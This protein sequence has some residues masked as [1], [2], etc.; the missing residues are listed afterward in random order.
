MFKLTPHKSAQWMY[1]LLALFFGVAFF[2]LGTA[3][4]QAMSPED[5][6]ELAVSFE[7]E[8]MAGVQL[9]AALMMTFGLLF[10]GRWRWSA[11]FRLAGAIVVVAL[12]AMLA[13]SSAFAPNGW[14][15]A[16]YNIGFAGAGMTIA[17]WNLVDVRAAIFW[18]RDGKAV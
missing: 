13:W 7:I 2:V 12:C 16:T 10:N 15:F 1:A 11:A 17:W 14:P 9:C 4:L 8:H 3:G 6:G 18:G 5:Y